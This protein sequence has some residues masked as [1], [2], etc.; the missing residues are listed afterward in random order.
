MTSDVVVALTHKADY[1]GPADRS[2]NP[3]ARCL[4][5]GGGRLENPMDF[6]TFDGF[7][8]AVLSGP[9][10]IEP[11]EWLRWVWDKMDG[12]QPP[13]LLVC[14]PPRE[15]RTA[16]TCQ[17]GGRSGPQRVVSMRFRQDQLRSNSIRTVTLPPR[18]GDRESGA[19]H[20][21]SVANDAVPS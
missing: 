20:L 17:E 11:S 8:C 13:D 14:S 5:V 21:L 3:E 16:T 12:K 15:R 2:G 7:I 10:T 9:K 18:S 1:V 6:F 19:K 4:S